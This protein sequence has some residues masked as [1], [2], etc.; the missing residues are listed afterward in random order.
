[1]DVTAAAGDVFRAVITGA[2]AAGAGFMEFEYC[3]VPNS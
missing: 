3:D 2:P 1:V